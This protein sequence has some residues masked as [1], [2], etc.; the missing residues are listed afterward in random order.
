MIVIRNVN[1]LG[2]TLYTLRPI[3][4]LHMQKPLEQIVIGVGQDL[5]GEMVRRQ[6]P[7][8]SVRD[9]GTLSPVENA[10]AIDLTAGRAAQL[11]VV[12]LYQYHRRVHISQCFAWLLGVNTD[13]WVGVPAPLTGWAN[14]HPRNTDVHYALIAP[15][16]R[17]CSRHV[18]MRP[19]K[20]PDHERWMQ[21]IEWL[22]DERGLQPTI[23]AGPNDNWTGFQC[24]K[25]TA[26]D[27]DDMT[28]LLRH[29]DLILT[30][31]N[32]I[33]H[34]ASALGC[35][36]LILWPPMSGV[37]FI[38]PL[39]NKSTRLLFMHPERVRGDQLLE[40]IKREEKLV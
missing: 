29:A 31:D 16:S 19:N 21:V 25:T 14:I 2:D 10:Q 40:I 28:N 4:E 15:F 22:R 27:L 7:M 3:A 6:F 12:Q 23:L 17:S 30:V 11:A 18:G 26:S 39:Y 13:H 33:G 38:G 34:L 37:D 5:A 24:A 8:L 35:K 36:T 32:G 9:A 1:L 20:T